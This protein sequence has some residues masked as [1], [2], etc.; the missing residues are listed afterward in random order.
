MLIE[1]EIAHFNEQSLL[2]S[3]FIDTLAAVTAADVDQSHLFLAEAAM[4]RLYRIYERLIRSAFLFHCSSSETINGAAVRSKLRCDD[5]ETAESIL[6]AGNKFLD[7]GNVVSVQK[8]A[9]LVFENGFPIRDLLSPVHSDL[10]DLQR[11]RNFVAHDSSEA[12]E[13]FKTAR[14]QYVKVGDVPPESVGTLALYRRNARSD[15]VLR[16]VHQ[17]VVRLSAI[18]S[19]L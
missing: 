13:G 3:G 17:K 4:F 6:K 19:S 1:D 11:F 2:L 12:A 16:I 7:W 9:S 18:L 8:L 5:C 14:T 10:I 15:I